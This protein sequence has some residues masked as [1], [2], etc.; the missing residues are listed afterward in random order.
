MPSATAPWGSARRTAD[1]EVVCG[2]DGRENI[3]C[4]LP[5]A[6]A[7]S[8]PTSRLLFVSGQ[9]QYLCTGE[10]IAGSNANTLNH[11]QPL[12]Q[13][14]DRDLLPAGQVQLPDDHLRGGAN[15]PTTDYAG[16]TF[17]KTNARRR[18]ETGGGST[19]R[20]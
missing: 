7:A 18:R 9:F 11:Q 19:T 15:A 13:H 8:N 10:L 3:A 17:L 6:S 5:A 2:T 1:P 14:P 4:H 20:S 16:G 12:H